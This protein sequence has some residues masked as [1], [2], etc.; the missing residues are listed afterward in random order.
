MYDDHREADEPRTQPIDLC[1]D[2]PRSQAF[3][4]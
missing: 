1:P 3:L 2:L 4:Q